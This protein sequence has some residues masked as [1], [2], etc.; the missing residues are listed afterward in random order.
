MVCSLCARVCAR[1]CACVFVS[2][3]VRVKIYRSRF[4]HSHS[5]KWM[6][7]VQCTAKH[8][9]RPYRRNSARLCGRVCFRIH[10]RR[11]SR[12]PER[13]LLHPCRRRR[14]SLLVPLRSL[15]QAL[16]SVQISCAGM[17]RSRNIPFT[18]ARC[19]HRLLQDPQSPQ[20]S[21][22]KPS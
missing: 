16:K 9:G 20:R 6:A 12:S 10:R 18:C 8:P 15:A 14:L 5:L 3:S 7:T 11:P 22:L 13:P 2:V 17:M 4:G 19:V 21:L 1:L